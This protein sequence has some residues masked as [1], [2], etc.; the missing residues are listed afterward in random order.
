M[1]I[2]MVV[3]CSPDDAAVLKNCV[4]ESIIIGRVA[5]SSGS[6]QVLLD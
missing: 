6:Q 4:P 5:K 3:F 2:G 1:G